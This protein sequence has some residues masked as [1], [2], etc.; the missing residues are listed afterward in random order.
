MHAEDILRIKNIQHEESVIEE[1]ENERLSVV[2]SIERKLKL[3]TSRPP[4]RKQVDNLTKIYV[5]LTAAE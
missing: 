1:L 2:R 3:I 4:T 5:D